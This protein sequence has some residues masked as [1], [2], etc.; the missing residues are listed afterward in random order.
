VGIKQDI[1]SATVYMSRTNRRIEMQ[2]R[3]IARSPTLN[4]GTTRLATAVFAACRNGMSEP[5]R[6]LCGAL[7]LEGYRSTT[8]GLK[9]NSCRVSSP[10]SR[11]PITK[12]RSSP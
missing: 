4:T 12:W 5:G 10:G 1:A 2:R 6:L 9:M 7:S 11:A 8:H 3:L